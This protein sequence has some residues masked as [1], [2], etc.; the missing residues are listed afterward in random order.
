MPTT[1]ADGD[2]RLCVAVAVITDGR[3]RFLVA[4]RPAQVEHAGKW[5]F[6]GGKLAVGE[7]VLAALVRECDEELGIRVLDAEPL[8]RVRHD[9]PARRV[10]LDA[11]RVSRFTGEP[12]GREGQQ[13]RWV[14][15]AEL[16]CLEFPEAN[17]AI[18]AALSRPPS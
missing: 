9:Y 1:A 2:D 13:V 10:L 17:R 5:E 8:I 3:G 14:A 18:V 7:T 15:A 6:P 4:R 12:R 16:G 11:W